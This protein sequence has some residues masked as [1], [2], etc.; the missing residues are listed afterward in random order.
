MPPLAIS[1]ADGRSK[2][3]TP[4]GLH[5]RRETSGALS[6]ISGVFLEHV[7]KKLLDFFIPTR[8]NSLILSESLSIKWFHLIGTSPKVGRNARTQRRS[9]VQWSMTSANRFAAPQHQRA[10]APM[11]RTLVARMRQITPLWNRV[12]HRALLSPSPRPSVPWLLEEPR[13]LTKSAP[14]AAYRFRVM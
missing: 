11:R 1:V 5:C 13:K 7:Q 12:V 4:A 8:S 2:T 10:H 14:L 6:L 9:A 3:R